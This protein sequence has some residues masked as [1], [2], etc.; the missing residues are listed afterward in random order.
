[1]RVR[2]MSS[3]NPQYAAVTRDGH[4][5]YLVLADSKKSTVF[6]TAGYLKLHLSL[7]KIH[8]LKDTGQRT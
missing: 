4:V 7:D 8:R 6:V 5:M 3:H 2:L 1:M